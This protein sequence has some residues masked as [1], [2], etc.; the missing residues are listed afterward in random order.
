MTETS[1][2]YPLHIR[3]NDLDINGHVNNAVYLMYFEEGRIMLFQDKLGQK[4]DWQKIS[5]LVVRNEVEYRAPI[6]LSD[7]V[8]IEVWISEFGNKS[9][10][11]SYRIIK[12]DP[13]KWSLCTLGKTKAVCIDMRRQQTIPVPEEWRAVFSN[14]QGH[15]S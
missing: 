10:E 13:T 1:K 2:S 9:L 14:Q 6:L 5:I 3:Y 4:W 12:K 8:R 15:S 7:E 11:F